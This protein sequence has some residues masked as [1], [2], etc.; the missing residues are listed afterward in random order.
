MAL[1]KTVA[2]QAQPALSKNVVD[3]LRDMIA[4]GQLEQGEHLKENE[5]ALALGVSRGPVREALTQ[6]ANE[7]YIELRRHRGAFVTTLTR[8]DIHEVYTLR[9]ALERLAMRRAATRMTSEQLAALDS[10]L[11]TMKKVPKDF[12]VHQAVELD[13]VFHDLVFE[14]ADHG[15]L[16]RSWQFIR[17]QVAFFLYARNSSHPDFGQ[18]G[19]DE[20]KEIRD[21]LAA[22]DPEAAAAAIVD[23]V[24][25]SYERLLADHPGDDDDIASGASD[26]T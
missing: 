2:L 3:V 11:E 20:H 24:T 18:V 26:I 7:G 15:R 9:L 10:V 22:G 12:T 5:I 19:Y 16:L 1:P 6:L 17:S 8:R 23:H 4:T 13:L 14:A 21:V 25:G